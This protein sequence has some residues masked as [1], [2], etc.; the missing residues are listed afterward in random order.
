M[1]TRTYIAASVTVA[2]VVIGVL[3]AWRSGHWTYVNVFQTIE[4]FVEIAILVFVVLEGI[5]VGEQVKEIHDST[6]TT[7]GTTDALQVG[8]RVQVLMP[9]PGRPRTEWPY[10]QEVY[11]VREV[12][13][14]NNRA[15][16]TPVL[17]S[18]NNQ[19]QTPTVTGPMT[20]PFS[21]FIKVNIPS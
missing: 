5:K 17:P 18:L 15:I 11:V 3:V 4:T 16:A 20:G 1:W 14:K 2:A 8:S 19:G 9:Q 21:P 13:K 10:S 7:F 12:D 6:A